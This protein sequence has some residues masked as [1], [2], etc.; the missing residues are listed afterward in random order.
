MYEC[1]RNVLRSAVV[2]TS[3]GV[4]QG[5]PLSC[6]LFVIYIDQL[7]KMLRHEV[8]VEGFFKILACA[9]VNG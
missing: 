3:V 7:V 2:T 1:I 5:G 6:L 8:D 9:I 4:R